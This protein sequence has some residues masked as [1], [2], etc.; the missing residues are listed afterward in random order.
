MAYIEIR[1]SGSP[2]S[3]RSEGTKAKRVRAVFRNTQEGISEKNAF[4]SELEGVSVKYDVRYKVNDRLASETFDTKREAESRV[5]EV[6]SAQARG[7][8]VDPAGGRI[9]FDELAEKWLA[10]NP[11]KRG[12]TVGRDR[13][14]LRAHLSP[15]IG[16]RQLCSIGQADVQELVNGLAE[17]L[18]PKTVE[19]TYGTLRA[20]FA[21][22][23]VAG[24]MG[25]SPC[26]D[27]NLPRARKRIRRV[28][29]PDDVGALANAMDPSYAPMVWIGALLGLRWSEVAG[30][31][32]RSLDL[33]HVPASGVTTTTTST[34]M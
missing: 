25:R 26:H 23:V 2:K 8:S 32:I 17:T 7:F 3:A 13:S 10:S 4:V 11:G 29:T 34:S 1:I 28:V 30:L 21:Y 19:R 12:S 24:L 20:A 31:R 6:E 27:V 22:A 14:A 16:N 33:G 15:A 18:A 9:T 5:T